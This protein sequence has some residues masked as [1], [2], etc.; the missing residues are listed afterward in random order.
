MRGAVYNSAIPHFTL[1]TALNTVN[2][3]P[4]FACVLCLSIFLL[5]FTVAADAADWTVPEQQ[6][7]RKIV[8]V[9]GPGAVALSIENRS[10]LTRR[11]SEIIQN[12]LRNELAALGLHFV[13][14][15]Q[16]AATVTI[17][18]SENSTAYVWVAQIRQGA[19]ESS[20]VMIS[21]PRPQGSVALRDSVPMT[22]RK[23]LLWTQGAPILDVAML[24]ESGT[25]PTHIAVL[26]TENVSIYRWQGAKWQLEQQ[27]AV[28]HSRAWP[29]DLHGR[30]V[31][32]RDHLFDVYLPGRFCQSTAAAPLSLNCR[33]SDD[34][35]PLLPGMLNG[36]AVSSF[37]SAG[38]GNG[39]T[40]LIPQERAFFAPSRNFFTG[41]ITPVVG[42][43]TT[44][45]KFYSAAVL[46]REKYNLWLFAGVDGQVHVVDG[47]SDQMVRLGWGSDLASVRTSCGAG[48]QVLAIS[49]GEANDSVRAYEIPDRDPVAVTTAIDFAGPI[50]ALW[51]EARGDT[52]IAVAENRDTGNYEAFRLAM[53]CSQ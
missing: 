37:P 15:E 21:P 20:V 39:A 19:S 49:P 34:P 5:L 14:A 22:L 31:P 29:R 27:L 24:D 53:V 9:T 6:L 23:T 17:S 11:D 7:A 30:L 46:P 18:L 2:R 48:W 44:V 8:A 25:T 4:R 40:I 16:A 50:T 51:T 13:K 41:A 33:D 10:S 36:G 32:A 43:F 3:A 26:D 47:V 35:W 42:K 38:I 52:A 12:G 45:T 1:S 28:T